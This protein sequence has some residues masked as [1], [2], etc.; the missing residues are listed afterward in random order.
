MMLGDVPL[1]WD[2]CWH[3]GGN[4]ASNQSGEEEDGLELH[5][6]LGFLT[7]CHFKASLVEEWRG[8]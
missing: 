3:R 7:P 5:G 2:L 8:A 6:G 4:R 1:A